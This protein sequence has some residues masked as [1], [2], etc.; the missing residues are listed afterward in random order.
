M[1]ELHTGKYVGIY[2]ERKRKGLVTKRNSRA[3]KRIA[4]LPDDLQWLGQQILSLNSIEWIVVIRRLLLERQRVLCTRFAQQQQL[5]RACPKRTGTKPHLMVS[6]TIKDTNG[7]DVSFRT[8]KFC[9]FSDDANESI[10]S[11]RD[12]ELQKG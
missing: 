11:S 7:E 10:E 1:S 9:G 8:C 3:R 6:L 12:A 5:A 2:K 4:D